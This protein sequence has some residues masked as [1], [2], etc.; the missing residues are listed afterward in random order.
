MGRRF[1]MEFEFSSL[2]T[3]INAMRNHLVAAVSNIDPIHCVSDVGVELS[4]TWSI[5]NEHCGMEITTPVFEASQASFDIVHNV[6]DYL[7]RQLRGTTTIRRDCGMHV[8]ID[9]QDFTAEQIK[10]LCRVFYTFEGTLLSLQPNSRRDNCYCTRLNNNSRDW[11]NHI[12]PDG[13]S[14][15]LNSHTGFI[16]RN[17]S[18]LSFKRFQ[19]RGTIEVRYAAGTIRGIKA[20]GWLRTIMMLVEISKLLDPRIE[21]AIT[22][23]IDDLKDFIREHNTGL[24]WLENLKTRCC[25]W[26][27]SRYQEINTPH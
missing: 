11:L 9:V 12:N 8:H 18:G 16:Y 24:E 7:R 10:M 26:I 21:M 23:N 20:V 25:R 14:Q 22:E 2:R 3:D 17:S 27:T 1:G 15:H 6:L 5:K 19:E 4:R 13:H